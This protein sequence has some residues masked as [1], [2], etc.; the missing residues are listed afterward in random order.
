MNEEM[1]IKMSNKC[2]PDI[3]K[4]DKGQ[5]IDEKQIA[6]MCDF[7]DTRF[8]CADFRLLSILRIIYS[9]ADQL[10]D[11]TLK[12]MEKTILSFKY[13]MDEPGEDSMCYWSENHQIIFYTCEYLAGQYFKD[14]VFTNSLM[15]G[16]QHMHKVRPKILNWLSNR[17]KYGFSEWHSNVYYEEDIAPMANLIDFCKDDEITRKTVIV[18]DVLL[19]DMALHS[20]KGLF[21]AASG[22]CYEEQKTDPKK[23]STLPVTDM[24]SGIE[25]V[26]SYD[27]SGL[28][29]HLYLCKNYT[30]PQVL[31]K[32]AADETDVVIKDSMGLNLTEIAKEFD[33]L[34]DFDT[35]GMFLWAMEAFTNPESINITLDIFNRWN[36]KKNNFLKNLKMINYSILRRFNILPTLIRLLNPAT[37]GIAIQRA[38]TYTW[39]TKNY[40]LSTA[41]KYHPGTFGDQQHLWQATLSKDISIFTT[42]P[43]C[44]IFDDQARNFSP[45]YW[46]GTGRMPH[47]AQHENIHMSIYVIDGKKGFLERGINFFTHAYFPSEKFDRVVLEDRYIFG[48][49]LDTYV[50]LTGRYALSYNDGSTFDLLQNG[51]ETYWVCELSTKEKWS[52]FDEFIQG[53]KSR[54]ITYANRIL[55]YNTT[56]CSLELEYGKDFKVNGRNIDVEYPR[57]DT[58][59]VKAG[60]KPKELQIS[61]EGSSLYLNFD[62]M[63]RRA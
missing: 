46:V 21:A 10:T 3:L 15:T 18:M 25:N 39:K 51:K 47:C 29:I 52:S 23:Q 56:E 5:S 40:M 53:I 24:L 6:D 22:R 30:V 16:R 59:Y 61:F 45:S 12:R 33:D 48:E 9:Y 31:K 19:L 58:P 37:Q 8:D 4:L 42:H 11:P 55:S 62:R 57:L 60:R 50:V 36:L 43:A 26:D 44:S 7:V 54:K 28:W 14:K 35:T 17:W 27:Y 1:T 13:W 63:E 38:N 32:I 34:S 41:Q 2:I 20:F 49:Y